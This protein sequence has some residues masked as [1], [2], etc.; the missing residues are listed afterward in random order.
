MLRK[1]VLKWIKKIAEQ[2]KSLE[3]NE[4]L[5]AALQALQ[6]SKDDVYHKQRALIWEIMEQKRRKQEVDSKVTTEASSE[7]TE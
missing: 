6:E 7:N 4:K 2:Q 1:M 5:I 3:S